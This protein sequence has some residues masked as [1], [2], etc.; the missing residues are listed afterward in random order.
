MDLKCDIHKEC[1]LCK[2][3]K[4]NLEYQSNKKGRTEL[5]P[6][7]K[8]CKPI[9]IGIK[10][11]LIEPE[12]YIG[13]NFDSGLLKGNL[14][15][16][17]YVLYEDGK[18]KEIALEHACSLVSQGAAHVTSSATI[19]SLIQGLANSSKLDPVLRLDVLKRDDFICSYCGEEGNTVDHVIAKA[20]GG[21]NTRLN[22]VCACFV[23]N[24][25][26]ANMSAR[27]FITRLKNGQITPAMITAMRNSVKTK[28]KVK[29]QVVMNH[30]SRLKTC[31]MCKES[32]DFVKFAK[33]K[34]KCYKCVKF[35]VPF[36]KGWI[37][38]EKIASI[39]TDSQ[40]IKKG[41]I[42][43]RKL[44]GTKVKLSKKIA[45]EYAR[46]GLVEVVDAHNLIMLF[47]DAQARALYPDY[48]NPEAKKGL[49]KNDMLPGPSVAVYSSGNYL[50][51]V[52]QYDAAKSVEDGI[53]EV[54]KRNRIEVHPEKTGK[55]VP[56]IGVVGRP[57][58]NVVD[59]SGQLIGAVKEEDYG[60]IQKLV[61]SQSAK[62][63]SNS[64]L[65]LLR[66]VDIINSAYP[67]FK[68]ERILAEKAKREL[69][70]RETLQKEQIDEDLLG[71]HVSVYIEGDFIGAVTS[72]TARDLVYKG[73]AEIKRKNKITAT[74]DM[75]DYIKRK[76]KMQYAE[77]IQVKSPIGA[78][79]GQVRKDSDEEIKK[80]I[81]KNLAVLKAEK[82]LLLK[83][84]PNEIYKNHPDIQL[85]TFVG[86]RVFK[87]I[88]LINA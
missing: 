33:G 30:D 73:N 86:K 60:L 87:E 70:I 28:N 9:Y 24:Q 72:E 22:L 66:E 26:K 82:E 62:L 7:C 31:P 14:N 50:G 46:R 52:D 41:E 57:S 81:S 55:I 2:R 3:K 37:T 18:Y 36:A 29:K 78:V 20:S 35:E 59:K 80:L 21:L 54:I 10:K 12:I 65:Q 27:M 67:K 6:F 63:K 68:I 84:W 32:K 51:A 48:L 5:K 15:D 77:V 34:G 23:C 75:G 58:I 17:V 16:K 83:E 61:S 43:M 40:V 42:M 19:E 44:D 49:A 1:V 11:G 88:L 74:A 4:H 25:L 8:A 38:S 39:S 69:K 56:L 13:K 53:G 45:Q 71:P 79:I 64:T 85:K 47:S 76:L